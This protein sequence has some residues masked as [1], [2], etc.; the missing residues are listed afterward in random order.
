MTNNKIIDFLESAPLNTNT[1]FVLKLVYFTWS[2]GPLSLSFIF[3][4]IRAL[5]QFGH[6]KGKLIYVI[7]TAH[8]YFALNEPTNHK[9]PN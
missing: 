1:V 9:Y 3:A 4:L 6:E 7:K 5:N 2:P 8:T